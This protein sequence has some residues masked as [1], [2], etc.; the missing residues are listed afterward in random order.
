MDFHQLWYWPTSVSEIRQ[1]ESCQFYVCGYKNY[2]QKLVYSLLMTHICCVEHIG[3][4]MKNDKQS[5][6]ERTISNSMQN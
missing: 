2:N 3:K 4:F 6:Q 1:D 5:L